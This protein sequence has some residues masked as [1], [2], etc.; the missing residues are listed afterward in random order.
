VE[1]ADASAARKAA[2]DHFRIFG[3]LVKGSGDRAAAVID[4]SD[5]SNAA[6]S[7]REYYASGDGSVVRQLGKGKIL[8][9]VMHAGKKVLTEVDISCDG[10]GSYGSS[11]A[12]S[13]SVG[14]SDGGRSRSVGIS[15][16]GG[17]VGGV[18]AGG[19]KS[20]NYKSRNSSAQDFLR[21]M[22]HK[23][24]FNAATGQ[25][26]VNL[27]GRSWKGSGSSKSGSSSGSSAGV[28]TGSRTS[29]SGA[30]SV[31]GASAKGVKISTTQRRDQ[32][33]GEIEAIRNG[34]NRNAGA[35]TR[36]LSGTLKAPDAVRKLKF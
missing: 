17:V 29:S 12:S 31:K 3:V 36:G 25:M 24:K 13:R 8:E 18:V 23:W 21:K 22:E 11:Y 5:A 28:G 16:V 1:F 35:D 7:G 6:S 9:E 34:G 19:G 26:E 33:Y 20:G 4:E 2:K 32:L 14:I 30:G 27:E 15:D 10:G